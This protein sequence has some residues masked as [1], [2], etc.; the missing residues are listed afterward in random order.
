RKYVDGLTWTKRL[1]P[2]TG[3]PLDYDRTKDVQ[4]YVE[5][6]H[7]TRAK[8]VGVRCPATSGGKNWEPAAYNPELKLIYI[9]SAEGC[10]Q[11]DLIVQQDFEDQGGPLK[12]RDRFDGGKN[13]R[14][15]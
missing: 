11:I 8:P 4:I 13:T 5:G 3:R 1:H 7:P 2:K 6:T 12:P 14:L 9:P 15:K 10:S